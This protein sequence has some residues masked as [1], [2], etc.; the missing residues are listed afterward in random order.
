MEFLVADAERM[1]TTNGKLQHLSYWSYK[2][3]T[4]SF[5]ESYQ[6]P[7]FF[8]SETTPENYIRASSYVDFCTWH[9]YS[10]F[11]WLAAQIEVEFPGILFPPIPLKE[12]DG[13][14]DKFSDLLNS[15]K[16]S[17][18][19][20]NEHP[21]VR[22]RMRQL[23]LTLNVVSQLHE[24]H[25]SQILKAFVTLDERGWF[26]FRAEQRAKKKTSLFSAVREKGLSL[27]SKLKSLRDSDDSENFVSSP[28][29]TIAAQQKDLAAFLNTC[30]VEVGNLAKHTTS[31][32]RQW[33]DVDALCKSTQGAPLPWT[34]CYSGHLVQYAKQK[35]LEGVVRRVDDKYAWVEW[36]GQDDKLSKVRLDELNY[37]SS[38][39]SDPAMFALQELTTQIDSYCMY[40]SRVPSVTALKDIEDTIWFLSKYASRCC[41]VIARLKEL[42]SQVHSLKLTTEKK[43]N[44]EQKERLEQLQ[45]ELNSASARLVNVYNTFY[46]PYLR[47]SLLG[48][49]RKLIE[50]SVALIANAEW[51]KRLSRANAMLTPRFENPPSDEDTENTL[52]CGASE[53]VAPSAAHTDA[54]GGGTRQFTPRTELHP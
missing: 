10:D 11:E 39:V 28:L 15:A 27:F 53:Q 14:M 52:T 35:E 13:T 20:S 47:E 6:N 34:A 50:T 17:D 2:I 12:A 43:P 29:G 42:G 21:L 31:E 8:P 24:I 23:Q 9:R 18:A 45:E 22:K 46:R 48:V 38:G 7:P 51:E 16:D 49:A 3:L 41:D 19:M 54:E 40:L 4:R 1:F 26:A 36:N 5:L 44:S 33:S 32:L 30:Y 37:P 25:E